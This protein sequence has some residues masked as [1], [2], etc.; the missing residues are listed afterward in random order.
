MI[1]IGNLSIQKLYVG[2]TDA[3]RAYV[4]TTEVYSASTP[5]AI[6]FTASS[7]STIGLTALSSNQTLE[8]STNGRTWNTLDTSVTISLSAGSYALVRGTLSG[9]NTYSDYTQFAITGAVSAEGDI[10]TLWDYQ[11]TTT[12]LKNNC[13]YKLFYGCSA[14]TNINGLALTATTLSTGCYYSMFEGCTGL[15]GAPELPATTLAS[16]CY[17]SMFYGCT[18][19]TTAPELPAT[20]LVTSC[21]E[22]MFRGCTSLVKSPELPATTLASRS[23]ANMFNGCTS[24][25]Y[26]KCNA[27]DIS[28]TSCTENWVKNVAASGVFIKN[29]TMTLW[30]SGDAGIPSGWTV[31]DKEYTY[32]QYVGSD[33]T[34]SAYLDTDYEPS[35]NTTYRIGYFL[36]SS[37]GY[38][39]FGLNTIDG[40]DSDWRIF[41]HEGG[42]Y[43]DWNNQRIENHDK[44]WVGIP[45]EMEVGNYYIQDL[46]DYSMIAEGNYQ[47]HMPT[48]QRRLTF[49]ALYEHDNAYSGY[50][51]YLQIYE[52][53][54]LVRNFIPAVRNADN[55]AGFYEELTDTFFA[56]G[57]ADLF[58]ILGPEQFE[59]VK[60]TANAASTVGLSRISSKQTLMY[61][62]DNGATW[63]NMTTSTSISLST[64]D[65]VY[66]RGVLSANTDEYD[67][68]QFTISGD[69]KASGKI[70]A[71]WNYEDTSAALKRYCGFRMFEGC[72][73]LTD[74]SELEMP[75]TTANN[76]YERMFYGCSNLTRVYNVLPATTL[77]QHCYAYMF[78][79]CSSL[80]TAPELPATYIRK[81]GCYAVMFQGCSSLSYIKCLA[82]DYMSAYQAT[83][84]WVDGVAATGVFVK[85]PNASFWTTGTGGIPSGWTVIDN[86]GAINLHINNDGS[87][88]TTNYVPDNSTM[89]EFKMTI[90]A[91][92]DEVGCGNSG[93]GCILSHHNNGRQTF[94]IICGG[95]IDDY[96]YSYSTGASANPVVIQMTN[97]KYTFDTSTV[98]TFSTQQLESQNTIYIGSSS[99]WTGDIYYLKIYENG[100]LVRDYEPRVSSTG[101]VLQDIITGN[102]CTYQGDITK[103]SIG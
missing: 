25:N 18:S 76:C 51:N 7:A 45:I 85:N 15:T 93:S 78:N 29:P 49:R 11:D 102:I 56:S 100:K 44:N 40:D 67:Y 20:T 69:V 43:F 46:S 87:K 39:V 88:F 34:S 6:K 86:D 66:V 99:G 16:N 103:V 90:N 9:A 53:G 37:T 4:G 71:L 1:N 30:T 35:I 82:T 10:N 17:Y 62:T 101:P 75:D 54:T 77:S 33:A 98:A 72:S 89:I 64:G 32:L 21:Y 55:T 97:R 8:Y 73:G 5:D 2:A 23:Y 58:N 65:S 12:A 36:N 26:M 84:S 79:G 83:S 42:M 22:A 31:L 92:G 52:N 57:N 13:G 24:L 91:N 63:S 19:L 59:A 80:T 60:F 68:T 81:N 70:N 48:R 50:I 96:A 95:Y 3:P 61:S 28:A 41:N 27:T 47:D 14:L 74:A 94:N 38:E